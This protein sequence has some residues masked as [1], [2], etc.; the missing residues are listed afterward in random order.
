M[1][2][3]RLPDAVRVRGLDEPLILQ[4]GGNLSEK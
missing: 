4:T 1:K 3:T 2:T